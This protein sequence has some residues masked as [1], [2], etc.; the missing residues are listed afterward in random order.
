MQLIDVILF[1]AQLNP[2]AL[3]LVGA[4]SVITYGRMAQG[5]LSAG[6]RLA[7]IGLKSGDVI[8]VS[9]AHP[10]DRLVLELSLA[11]LG[12]TTASLQGEI[13]APL[14]RVAFTAIVSDRPSAMIS[15]ERLP[16]RQI[17][18]DPSWFQDAVEL[19]VAER[20][21]PSEVAPDWV[22]RLDAESFT[23]DDRPLEVSARA[24]ELQV[25]ACTFVAPCE[26]SRLVT[27]L[28][29]SSMAGYRHALGALTNG[30]TISFTDAQN[31]RQISAAYR[32]HYLVTSEQDLRQIVSAQEADFVPLPSLKGVAVETLGSDPDLLRRAASLLSPNLMSVFASSP[33]GILAYGSMHELVS[34]P[35]AIGVLGPWVEHEMPSPF[36]EVT[37][38]T[39]TR[40]RLRT[41]SGSASDWVEIRQGTSSL[42]DRR[43]LMAGA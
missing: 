24:L 28:P 4:G 15:K 36:G 37:N 6:R 43:L 17:I 35:G 1:Q 8:G 2:A 7:A 42:G 13:R 21:L 31:F 5:I 26:W 30:R 18:I 16:V 20:Q 23:A 9:I 12:I 10:I 38:A 32:H 27:T 3:S 22:C 33:L 29:P 11:R 19:S 40:L 34:H 41:A 14:D 39:R 25:Q